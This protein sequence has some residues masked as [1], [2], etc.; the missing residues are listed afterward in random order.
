MQIDTPVYVC[1][2]LVAIADTGDYTCKQW[3]LDASYQSAV[4]LSQADAQIIGEW[5][6]SFFVL[7]AAYAIITKAIKLA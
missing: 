1:S 2:E 5:L 4:A 6:V 7:C 3:V